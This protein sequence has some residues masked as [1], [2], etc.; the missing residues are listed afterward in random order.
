MSL[1]SCH[2]L[3]AGASTIGCTDASLD[4]TLKKFWNLEAIG[5]NPEESSVYDDFM[6]TITFQNGR[7]CVRLPWKSYHPPLPDNYN[8]CQKK[9][10]KLQEYD[11]IIKYQID[12]GIVEVVEDPWRM[13]TNKL[14]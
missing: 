1:L 5:I 2:T 7:Y 13:N 14:H 3:K 9:L 10:Y 12:Q 6:H 4:D 11:K 8:L